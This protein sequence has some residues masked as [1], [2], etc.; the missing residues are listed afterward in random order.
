MPGIRFLIVVRTTLLHAFCLLCAAASAQ[1][2]N[3]MT[4]NLDGDTKMVNIQQEFTYRNDSRDTLRELYFNDWSHASSNKNTALAKRFAEDFK[5]SLHLAK[6]SERGYTEIVSA[7]DDEYRGIS[8]K[9]VSG[10]DILKFVLNKPLPP[11]ASTVLFI[12]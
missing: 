11:G 2:N 1:H 10:K 12:T 7:V 3:Q 4:A 6:K 8:W 9:R 5:K